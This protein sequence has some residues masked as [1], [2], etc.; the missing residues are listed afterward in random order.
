[1][2]ILL[3]SVGRRAPAIVDRVEQKFH[4]RSF[5]NERTNRHGSPSAGRFEAAVYK[6]S[7]AKSNGSP[8]GALNRRG[9]I[10][11][12]GAGRRR[13]KR[14]GS[15][16]PCGILRPDRTEPKS[17]AQQ[18]HFTAEKIAEINADRT[19]IYYNECRAA[20]RRLADDLLSQGHAAQVMRCAGLKTPAPDADQRWRAAGAQSFWIHY[21]VRL[22]D[23]II[24][25]T[26]RQFFPGCAN[27]FRQS[28][29]SFAAEWDS[30]DLE[31]ENPRFRA[32]RL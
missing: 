14:V 9:A 18:L 32:A 25:L 1:L 6:E 22:D 2:G 10:H 13:P 12:G 16:N 29:V 28:S 24:D 30:F 20:S 26:R 21:V 31:L 3:V 19:L 23:Y 17:I 7:A 27:P 8:I 11:P 4:S 5:P 15:N